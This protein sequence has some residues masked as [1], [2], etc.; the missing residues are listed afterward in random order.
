MIW[1][2]VAI[3]I[4]GYLIA[5]A[6]QNNSSKTTDNNIN[7]QINEIEKQAN[8]CFTQT[9]SL[10]KEN[11]EKATAQGN[12]DLI[13]SDKERIRDIEADEAKYITLKEKLKHAS[14]KERLELVE[15]WRDLMEIVLNVAFAF[16]PPVLELDEESLKRGGIR[17]KEIIKRFDKKLKES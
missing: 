16:Q 3:L 2:A 9:I 11:L 14:L 15:D 12:K 5:K 1:I 4:V 7:K 13:K 8:N 6:I 10:Y 17:A